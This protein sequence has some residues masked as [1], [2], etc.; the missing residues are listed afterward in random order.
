M[1]AGISCT[2]RLVVKYDD[3][4]VSQG[5]GWFVTRSKVIT[6]WHVI[7]DMGELSG[8]SFELEV[9]GRS[10]CL[11]YVCGSE[12]RNSDVAVLNVRETDRQY[13]PDSIV[14]SL[15]DAKPKQNDEWYARG[16]PH[17]IGG[18]EQTA[19]GNV[20][21]PSTGE[22]LLQLYVKQNTKDT[23]EGISG[24]PVIIENRVAGIFTAERNF[25]AS[26]LAVPCSA[27]EG[28]VPELRDRPHR[29]KYA[30]WFRDA[31][32]P[33]EWCRVYPQK[34]MIN[35]RTAHSI[36]QLSNLISER[37]DCH[38]WLI[39]G[40]E[41][42]GREALIRR[43]AESY[44]QNSSAVNDDCFNLP[45]WCIT[46][47]EL[48]N[49]EALL[50]LTQ[51][52]LKEDAGGLSSSDIDRILNQL[53]VARERGRALFIMDDAG[54]DDIERFRKGIIGNCLFLAGVSESVAAKIP[55]AQI[56]RIV[57]LSPEDR[58]S[59]AGHWLNDEQRQKWIGTDQELLPPMARP[60]DVSIWCRAQP[61]FERLKEG[62]PEDPNRQT[63]RRIDSLGSLV[64]C[65]LRGHPVAGHP[66][67]SGMLE[68]RDAKVLLG[69]L[70]Y[71]TL[72][73]GVQ[74]IGPEYISEEADK[75]RLSMPDK[76][77]VLSCLD[78]IERCGLLQKAKNDTY[79][80]AHSVLQEY[81]AASAMYVPEPNFNL[82]TMAEHAAQ[83]L[84]KEQIVRWSR[85]LALR[86]DKQE[87]DN[88]AYEIIG[89]LL[90]YGLPDGYGKQLR[91][92][93]GS[94]SKCV[95]LAVLHTERLQGKELRK[96]LGW[97]ES[98]EDWT[99]YRPDEWRGFEELLRYLDGLALRADDDESLARLTSR[100]LRE[101]SIIEVALIRYA[102][103][104][105]IEKRKLGQR[106]VKELE[107][108]YE[109]KRFFDLAGH[110]CKDCTKVR[111]DFRQVPEGWFFMGAPASEERSWPNEYP[112]HRVRLHKYY[113]SRAEVTNEQYEVFDPTHKAFRLSE[114]HPE[115]NENWDRHPVVRVS[116]YE[117]WCF[118]EWMGM[119]LPTEMKWEKAARGF[120]SKARPAE[121][122]Q[123]PS[124][125]WFT[126][127][128]DLLMNVAWFKE[129]SGGCTAAVDS[130]PSDCTKIKHPFDLGGCCG[131]VW[132]WCMDVQGYKYS[133]A[134]RDCPYPEA[135]EGNPNGDIITNRV[136]RGGSYDS[137]AW[138]CR[139][140]MRHFTFPTVRAKTIGFRL[141][142]DSLPD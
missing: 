22:G 85:S 70:A 109:R 132:E 121:I 24:A 108:L 77:E 115:Q 98:P 19:S 50:G 64:D 36:E 123:D 16:F 29:L 11:D 88:D 54:I 59:L 30:D 114:D 4:Q 39:A 81:M 110:S 135:F 73:D 122:P 83:I 75:N 112:R 76:A 35:E 142:A 89:T 136:I 46:P 5:T 43:V 119:K 3:K 86:L 48:D 63:E 33:P 49:F 66:R 71:L 55:D 61:I 80:F 37:N 17:L 12:N 28:I 18:K 9:N 139:H 2:F 107:R 90:N 131:N 21:N 87:S 78:Q 125:Y 113:M 62:N 133:E 52:K 14:L 74:E 20:D 79:R 41:S 51:V 40:Y 44:I 82:E 13:I 101:A 120:N 15:A 126:G 124:P 127:K 96:A 60:L 1:Y 93:S 116:W 134:D 26:A 130:E 23:W 68:S 65:L 32:R 129:N 117:A 47:A 97:F 58:R 102:L 34:V 99:G 45:I 137:P 57:P 8:A 128:E 69:G 10:I 38:G 42:E 111:I 103:A 31:Y 72:I 100:I 91:N 104:K 138:N 67:S 7:R 25:Y 53:R 6:A 118:G 140:A 141:C 106:P 95:C 56:C 94:L 27:L 105:E 92:K 84:N